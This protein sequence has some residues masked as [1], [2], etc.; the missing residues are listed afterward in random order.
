M[1][2]IKEAIKTNKKNAWFWLNF[3]FELALLFIGLYFWFI[4]ILLLIM[5]QYEIGI[6]L[7][8]LTSHSLGWNIFVRT[9]L[10]WLYEKVYAL[11]PKTVI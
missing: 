8:F 7:I 4:A 9:G 10:L 11:Y 6:L 1:K 5:A 3:F 2:S